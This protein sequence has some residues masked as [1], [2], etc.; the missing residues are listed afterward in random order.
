MY[1]RLPI[2][3]LA[4]AGTAGA[5]ANGYAADVSARRFTAELYA[6]E[7]DAR[8]DYSGKDLSGLDLSD[9]DFKRAKLTGANLFGADLTD[10]NLS[11]TDLQHAR[12]DRT[13]VLRANFAYADLRGAS[14]IVPAAVVVMEQAAADA[15]SFANATLA[16]ARIV[17]KFWRVNFREADLSRADFSPDTITRRPGKTGSTTNSTSLPTELGA[18]DFTWAKL[19]GADL[20]RVM[21]RFSTFAGADL[22][23]ADL[24]NADFS[25]TDLSGADLAGANIAGTNF[26][27]ANM[28]GVRGLERAQ[29]REE[30]RNLVGAP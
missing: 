14:L 30:A 25:R 23:N 24:G 2:V 11:R 6:A 17:G 28:A 8:L 26:D 4:L 29:G 3:L 1:F 18:C 19:S 16:G 15:P 9:I 13:T 7:A 20:R 22:T 5:V 10:A 21:V 27:G 12:L